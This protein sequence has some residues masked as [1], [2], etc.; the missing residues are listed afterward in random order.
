MFTLPVHRSDV[1][2]LVLFVFFLCTYLACPDSSSA[3]P[4]AE[5]CHPADSILL[6][7]DQV[8]SDEGD[9]TTQAV[10]LNVPS[11]GILFVE[12]TPQPSKARLTPQEVGCAEGPRGEDVFVVEQSSDH[13]LIAFRSPGIWSLGLTATTPHTTLGTWEIRTSFVPARM[14]EE[15]IPLGNRGASAFRAQHI[16]FF[17]APGDYPSPQKS[18]QAVVDPD[19]DARLRQPLTEE[20]LLSLVTFYSDPVAKSE[21]AVV[22]PDPD[23]KLL[24]ESSPVEKLAQLVLYPAGIDRQVESSLLSRD[25][26]RG[27]TLN[28]LQR[29][30]TLLWRPALR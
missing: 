28:V 25:G 27:L 13:L 21:Q 10:Y 16:E 23:N 1:R 4:L 17:A 7:G 6:G 3:N 5:T 15:E 24:L 20:P 19:P 26:R 9:G 11:S 22:D 2:L 14:V 18:E 8:L 12:T 30:A 29:L